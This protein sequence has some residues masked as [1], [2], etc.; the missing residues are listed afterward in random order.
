MIRRIVIPGG[1]GRV[2]RVL[3]R[4]FHTN[5][6]AVTVLSRKPRVEAWPV[7]QWNGRDLAHWTETIDGADVVI[8]LTGRNVD[9]RYTAANRREIMDSRV[10]A[11][12]VIGRAIAQAAHPP[13]LW[14]NASTATI[15]RHALDRAMDDV[16][17]EL[18]GNE[19]EAPPSW[20]FSIE[21][22]KAWER[23]F[24]EAATPGTRKIA[25]RSAITMSPDSGGVLDLLLRLVRCGFGGATGS[26]RQFVSWVHERDFI[27][28]L[29]FLMEHGEM[30][31]RINIAAPHPLPNREFMEELRRAA[32]VRVGLPA[33]R[34]MLEIGAFFLRTETELIL[35]S[36]RVVA[37]RLMKA[38]FEF[39][40]SDWPQAVQDL[41]SRQRGHRELAK[42]EASK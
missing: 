21:V 6:D 35:K 42:I 40:F 22:A 5:G 37:R 11:T 41:V 3:A 23:V 33:S 2:G 19:K 38:G 39:A 25:L 9:C 8:N 27:R 7:I 29:E 1:S 14:M 24:F 36:R 4:H 15:Y 17:G 34:W 12:Q 30:D 16:T 32:G 28:A 20:H 26:G 13:A 31:G 18:G 10:C